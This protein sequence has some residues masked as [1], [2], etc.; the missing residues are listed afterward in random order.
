MMSYTQAAYQAEYS[1]VKQ[2]IVE[3]AICTMYQSVN[4]VA[5]AYQPAHLM[6]D[7]LD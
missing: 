7:G 4:Q 1:I 2:M 5:I 6:H 3:A